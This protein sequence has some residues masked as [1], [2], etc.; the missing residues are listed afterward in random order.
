LFNRVKARLEAL[1]T[2]EAVHETTLH[3]TGRGRD[4]LER[5]CVVLGDR[6][7]RNV[8]ESEAVAVLADYFLERE[9]PLRKSPG[10]RRVGDTTLN[11]SRAVPAEVERLVR[12]RSGSR[13]EVPLCDT[14]HGLEFA[15]IVAHRDG[16]GREA[17]DLFHG[18][19]AHHVQYDAGWFRVEMVDGRPA[20]HFTQS[21][22]PWRGGWPVPPHLRPNPLASR[23][24]R[25]TWS[26]PPP[27]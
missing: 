21:N 1:R 12:A 6:A 3:L 14:T 26:R 7:R 27:E 13:C 10:T 9:D 11:R 22:G 25:W 8:S 2:G 18:C 20:F 5:S 17:K 23:A 24:S 4:D 15:H 19:H 16:G